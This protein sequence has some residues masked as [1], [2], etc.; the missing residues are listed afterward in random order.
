MPSLFT[1][2]HLNA[3]MVLLMMQC[4]KL[5]Y[6]LT[7]PAGLVNYFNTRPAVLTLDRMSAKIMV[8]TSLKIKHYEFITELINLA[9]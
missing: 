7:G 6:S 9:N 5:T 8:Q 1:L 2:D 4:V 3:G